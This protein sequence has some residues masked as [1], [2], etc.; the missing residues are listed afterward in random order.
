[1]AK[2]AESGNQEKEVVSVVKR[3]K[4]YKLKRINIKMPQD[5]LKNLESSLK[6]D[7]KSTRNLLEI[8]WPDIEVTEEVKEKCKHSQKYGV[9]ARGFLRVFYTNKEYNSR[10]IKVLSTPLP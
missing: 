3:I 7:K 10:R 9:G 8:D 6:Q 2:M 5:S 1:M 4:I